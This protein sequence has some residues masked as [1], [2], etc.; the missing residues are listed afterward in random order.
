MLAWLKRRLLR[1]GR[2]IVRW[3]SLDV[4]EDVLVVDLSRLSQNLVGVKRRVYGVYRRKCPPPDFP[5]EIEWMSFRRVW[6][7]Q[8]RTDAVPFT[9]DPQDGAHC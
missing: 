9:N 4:R 8:F 2:I 6:W 7:G 3:P 1:E 5:S